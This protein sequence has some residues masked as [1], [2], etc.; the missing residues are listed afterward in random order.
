MPWMEESLPL[1]FDNWLAAYRRRLRQDMLG[2]HTWFEPVSSSCDA[3]Y[4]A[5]YS[6][7]YSATCSGAYSSGTR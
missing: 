1:R 7:I 3:A 5:T 4:S 2:V 6:A